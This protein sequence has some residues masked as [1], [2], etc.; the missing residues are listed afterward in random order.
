MVIAIENH[1][2]AILYCKQVSEVAADR[3]ERAGEVKVGGQVGESHIIAK[4]ARLEA[5]GV[6]NGKAPR[7]ERGQG[8]GRQEGTSSRT[9]RR[10]HNPCRAPRGGLNTVCY[11]RELRGGPSLKLISR[12]QGKGSQRGPGGKRVAKQDKTSTT[13]TMAE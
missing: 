2:S 11:C 5:V 6:D 7:L 4:N 9:R 1:L 13:T 10:E 12:S 8:E 3:N